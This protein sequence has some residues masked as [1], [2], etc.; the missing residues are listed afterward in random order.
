MRELWIG[1]RGRLGLG[2]RGL[3][4]VVVVGRGRWKKTTA[5]KLN[6]V[7]KGVWGLGI[8]KRRLGMSSVVNNGSRSRLLLIKGCGVCGVFVGRACEK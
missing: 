3:V 6:W 2:G 8:W 7:G 5:V 1:G 4:L